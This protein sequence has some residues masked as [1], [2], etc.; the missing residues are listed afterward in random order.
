MIRVD[1]IRFSSQMINVIWIGYFGCLI[2]FKI[3]HLFG[4]FSVCHRQDNKQI[5]LTMKVEPFLNA[6][7]MDSQSSSEILISSYRLLSSKCVFQF[8]T[9]VMIPQSRWT[10]VSPIILF[11]FFFIFSWRHGQLLAI[12][13]RLDRSTGNWSCCS[14]GGLFRDQTQIWE[15]FSAFTRSV[16]NPRSE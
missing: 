4:L 6:K 2:S 14:F 12:H 13:W 5:R 3:S 8:K 7:L 9:R 15:T 10:L 1:L 16:T 11:L